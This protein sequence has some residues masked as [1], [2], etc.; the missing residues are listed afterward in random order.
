MKTNI[1][2]FNSKELESIQCDLFDQGYIWYGD[3]NKSSSFPKFILGQNSVVIYPLYLTLHDDM[4]ITWIPNNHI[5][6][7]DLRKLKLKKL[8]GMG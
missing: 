7:Q 6:K 5:S 8:N 3:S 1:P 2:I 4:T